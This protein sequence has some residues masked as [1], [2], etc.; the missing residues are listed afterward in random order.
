MA[1]RGQR[2]PKETQEDPRRPKEGDTGG[3]DMA[4][5]RQ[6][7][8]STWQGLDFSLRLPAANLIYQAGR[9]PGTRQLH[10]D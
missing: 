1:S 10:S 8:D 7:T 3:P 2:R 9:V 5:D 6:Q 4:A